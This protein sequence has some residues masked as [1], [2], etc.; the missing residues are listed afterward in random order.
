VPQPDG[1][2]RL[3]RRRGGVLGHPVHGPATKSGLV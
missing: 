3:L 2:A 1:G